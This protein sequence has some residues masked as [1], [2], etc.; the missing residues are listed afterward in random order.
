MVFIAKTK[1]ELAKHIADNPSQS[2]WGYVR[3]SSKTQEDGQSLDAQREAIEKYCEQNKL[4]KV[5]FVIEIASATK[6]LFSVDMSKVTKKKNE[7]PETDPRPLFLQLIAHITQLKHSHLVVWKLD[8]FA[9]VN[10]DQEMI[11]NLLRTEGAKLHSTLSSE[12]AIIAG[13]NDDPMRTMMRQ[14]MGA[15]AQYE[16]GMIK[17]R[18]D[19]GRRHKSANGGYTGGRPMYGYRSKGKK[20]VINENEAERIRYVYK[21]R[22]EYALSQQGIASHINAGKPDTDPAITQQRVSA[23]LSKS[24]M[25]LYNGYYTDGY[26]GKQTFHKNLVIIPEEEKTNELT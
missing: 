25:H 10:H 6:P 5:A 4:G 12:T 17:M 2:V 11:M 16:A 14:I 20:L 7:D 19:M 23:I 9:R 1:D 21:L 18:M 8:R 22:D 15:V 26:Y 13:D 24:S 3:V